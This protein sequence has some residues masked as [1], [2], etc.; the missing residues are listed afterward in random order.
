MN[1]LHFQNIKVLGGEAMSL[2]WSLL[3]GELCC[4]INPASFIF[5]K[6][7]ENS[8]ASA[9]L[10]EPSCAAEDNKLLGTGR[11][12]YQVSEASQTLSVA[13]V[14]FGLRCNL[15]IPRLHSPCYYE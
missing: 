7:N 10:A 2:S 12:K 6:M 15:A 4:Q 14:L 8:W 11:E 3:S 9:I 1:F 5:E 13:R